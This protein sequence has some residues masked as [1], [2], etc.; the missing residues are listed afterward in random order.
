MV[1]DFTLPFRYFTFRVRITMETS[2]SALDAFPVLM[3]KGMLQLWLK[4]VLKTIGS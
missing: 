3:G 4:K 2:I 1:H